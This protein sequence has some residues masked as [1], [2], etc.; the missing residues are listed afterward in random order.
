MQHESVRAA[1]EVVSVGDKRQGYTTVT[2]CHPD[3]VKRIHTSA[4]PVAACGTLAVTSLQPLEGVLK[5]RL[6]LQLWHPA[7]GWVRA[8]SLPQPILQAMVDRKT[9][10]ERH[11]VVQWVGDEL[12]T[13]HVGPIQADAP[14]SL[15]NPEVR[16]SKGQ[17]KKL[18]RK[19]R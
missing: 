11:R 16:I 1:F 13:L 4:R 9:T 19:G 6:Q 3:T 18:A 5:G 2:H 8:D 15:G 10:P 12:K 7:G 17:M 14:R